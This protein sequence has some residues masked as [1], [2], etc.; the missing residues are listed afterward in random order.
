MEI[1]PAHPVTQT[2]HDK[3]HVLLVALMIK[4][5]LTEVTIELED[6]L[7]MAAAPDTCLLAIEKDNTFTL[8]VTTLA[9][10]RRIAR[11]Q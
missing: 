5:G 11:I 6:L 8:K 2:L 9:E 1:N 3:W 4:M 7:T 10:A